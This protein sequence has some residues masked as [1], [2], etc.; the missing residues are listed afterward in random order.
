M[1]LLLNSA[2]VLIFL[3]GIFGLLIGGRGT[4]VFRSLLGVAV[5][6]VAFRAFSG[7]LLSIIRP[8]VHL[9]LSWVIRIIAV[10]GLIIGIAALVR[11]LRDR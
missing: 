6:L 4:R 10:V 9:V 5:I 1:D 8:A 11:I 2:I 7:P 3:V